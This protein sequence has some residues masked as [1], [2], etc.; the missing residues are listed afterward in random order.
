M[1]SYATERIAAGKPWHCKDS[2]QSLHR[3][4][5]RD[6]RVYL[7]RKRLAHAWAVKS[8]L[9]Q[10]APHAPSAASQ[11]L[12]F[13]QEYCFATA[14]QLTSMP[15]SGRGRPDARFPI[16]DPR[17][18]GVSSRNFFRGSVWGF[19]PPSGGGRY[20]SSSVFICGRVVPDPLPSGR[21]RPRMCESCQHASLREEIAW[22]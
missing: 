16:I 20:H 10:D 8:R 21:R 18:Y 14:C 5:Q 2:L 17:S 12:G 13:L 3:A 6:Y 15:D 19:L 9:P 22:P 1:L 4:Q 11:P 7:H